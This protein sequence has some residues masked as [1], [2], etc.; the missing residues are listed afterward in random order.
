MTIPNLKFI[1]SEGCNIPESIKKDALSLNFSKSEHILEY[2]DNCETDF[3]MFIFEN[4]K[5][6]T[7]D[8]S[9]LLTE[10]KE[11]WS[12]LYSEF[13]DKD[14]KNFPLCNYSQGSVR[15]DFDF[16]KC[17]IINNQKA[18]SILGSL[19]TNL[20]HAALYDLRL[21]LSR[22]G[23]IVKTE[24]FYTLYNNSNDPDFENSHFSYCD[25][26]NRDYQIEAE[27][28]FTKYLKQI[29]AYIT[30]CT[31]EITDFDRIVSSFKYT[32]SVII[33]VKNRPN[34]IKDAINSALSQKTDFD[35]NVIVIN[36]H[37]ENSTTE[38]IN[39]IKN[40]R[41]VHLIPKEE[42]LGIGGCWNLGI[43]NENCGAFAVQ[44]DSDDVYSDTDTL[45][46]IVDTF[47][48]E[49]CGVVIGSYR[50]TDIEM[51][52]LNNLIIDHREYTQENGA[53][54]ALRVNGFGA[55][56]C[57]FT[58]AV[59]QNQF[60]NFSYG[61]DY[62]LC[63]RLSRKYKIARIFDVLYLCRRWSGNSDANLNQEA[64]TRN[65]TSKDSFRTEEIIA[66]TRK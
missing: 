58:P 17:M 45:Q 61:E 54:N 25:P 2:F 44:L 30:P 53:N 39:S 48:K 29:N 43:N 65:N 3:T 51:K 1:V 49:K 36:N 12:I 40:Q 47:R 19:D 35:F 13:T 38:A 55:P 50:L 8:I 18:K 42:N 21:Q 52:P 24:K 34:T 46:K 64:I 26:R 60:K 37:S 57:Y 9:K 62:D 32:A 10:H 6:S 28:V 27:K 20:N 22:V 66:R 23:E 14:G 33:P 41:L 4:I 5:F 31:S 63:L 11:D 56:R 15:D 7:A 16:G 59:R